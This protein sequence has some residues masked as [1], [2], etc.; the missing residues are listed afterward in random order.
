[1]AQSSTEQ[2][3]QVLNLSTEAAQAL[4]EQAESVEAAIALHFA[5]HPVDQPSSASTPLQRL[6]QLIP[7][8]GRHL[9]HLLL[10][11]HRNNVERAADDYFESDQCGNCQLL[12]SETIQVED[13]SEGSGRGAADGSILSES[14]RGSQ[15]Q[16]SPSTGADPSNAQSESSD[17]SSSHDGSY[18][19]DARHP[20]ID[21]EPYLIP[22]DSYRILPD[23]GDDD[24]DDDA[25][26]ISGSEYTYDSESDHAGTQLIEEREEEFEHSEDF[27]GMKVDSEGMKMRF[28]VIHKEL[29]LNSL[30]SL[31][32][33]HCSAF[34][35]YL[36]IHGMW[37]QRLKGT[38]PLMQYRNATTGRLH[39]E[40]AA[41]LPTHESPLQPLAFPIKIGSFELP[42]RS[43]S[44][45]LKDRSMRR[46][47]TLNLKD[48]NLVFPVRQ[49][50]LWNGTDC[51]ERGGRQDFR[52]KI[53]H[54]KKPA[55]GL[56][57]ELDYTSNLRRLIISMES[58]SMA[59]KVPCFT[60]AIHRTPMQNGYWRFVL[61]VT[62]LLTEELYAC[63][64]TTAS[65]ADYFGHEVREV[66]RNILY[67]GRGLKIG[68][69][70]DGCLNFMDKPSSL[71]SSVS[72]CGQEEGEEQPEVQQR[73][74][75]RVQ[76][77]LIDVALPPGR[78]STMEVCPYLV[79][80][81]KNYQ[82]IG[83]NW[84][85]RRERTGSALEDRGI[86]QLHPMW[87]QLI[88]ADGHIVYAR[89]GNFALSDTFFC[90]PGPGTTG[91]I[92]SDEMGLGKSIQTLML[93]ICNPAPNDWAVQS[94]PTERSVESPDPIPIKTTLIVVPANLL[95]QWAEEIEAHV[96]PGALTWC[97][98]NKDGVTTP[99]M[100]AEE[101]MPEGGGMRR[102][103]R[104]LITS[105]EDINRLPV[106]SVLCKKGDGST[107]LMHE[108]DICLMSYEHL[109]SELGGVQPGSSHLH[110]Y[111]FWRVVLD[112][113]QLVTNSSSVAA[114]TASSLWRRHAW[115]VTGTPITQRVKEVKGLLEFLSCEP[116]YQPEGW[117]LL[118]DDRASRKALPSLLRGL[119][120]RRTKQA[121]QDELAL[122]TCIREDLWVDLSAVERLV[123]E[124]ARRSFVEGARGLSVLGY[125]TKNKNKGQSVVVGRALSGYTAMRQACCHPQLQKRRFNMDKERLSMSQIL[126]KLVSQAYADWD[127]SLRKVLDARLIAA[128]IDGGGTGSH[129]S[130][131]LTPIIQLIKANQAAALIP[132]VH[133][134]V[135]DARTMDGGVH[136]DVA[137]VLSAHLVQESSSPIAAIAIGNGGASGSG[138]KDASQ[139]EQH[140]LTGYMKRHNVA[141]MS[142]EAL[143]AGAAGVKER[144]PLGD[145]SEQD[146]QE[147]K[148]A[149][150]RN[151][152]WR[153]FELSALEL[154]GHMLSECNEVSNET[155]QPV[156]KRA[157][158]AVDACTTS[159]DVPPV[160]LHAEIQAHNCILDNLRCELGLVVEQADNVRRSRR[161][162]GVEVD[163]DVEVDANDVLDQLQNAKVI[164]KTYKDALNKRNPSRSCET[165]VKSASKDVSE[166]WHHLKHLLNKEQAFLRGKA[167]VEVQGPSS[168]VEQLEE[169]NTCPICLDDLNATS[170]SITPCGHHYHP[171]CIRECLE[172]AAQCPICRAPLAEGALMEAISEEE[173]R[174]QE[175][176][177]L[178][179]SNNGDYG[180]KITALLSHFSN[181]RSKDKGSKAVV[182][183]SWGRLLRL[184]NIAFDQ[185]GLGNT[186]LLGTS[187]ELRQQAVHRFLHDPDCVVLTLLMSNA[188]GAA[189]LTL[190]VANYAYILEPSLNP[191]LEA[192]ASARIYRLGQ[193]KETR[194]VR[195]LARST[196]EEIIVETQ[197]KKFSMDKDVSVVQEVE[198]G[199]LLQLYEALK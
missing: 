73:E 77:L 83:F 17:A 139:S 199:D 4:L 57:V 14:E 118:A 96:K 80:C 59:L 48:Y 54:K 122:P 168:G 135:Q 149:H 114:I 69:D 40:D 155:A 28:P 112:E 182:F 72:S 95:V 144:D 55:N 166:K 185:A 127:A 171:E 107:V 119:L 179:E 113:A 92:L 15:Q 6:R 65:E 147:R 18:D 8:L 53:L 23:E 115:V 110:Q 163:E 81:P 130:I 87:I 175:E 138:Q 148:D 100:L 134:A 25:E 90:A 156:H 170:R 11:R 43:M 176:A 21:W 60:F 183:S 39:C 131:R 88:T 20:M 136:I 158:R 186:T 197:R 97:Y 154:Y 152:H 98:Y 34:L 33:L 143:P 140:T 2:I 49:D 167:V 67:C 187:P 192:Q 13:E 196:V 41:L 63:V 31:D 128:A 123:Y 177:K 133:V 169:L 153:R 44:N 126:R 85:L 24:L 71:A 79:T 66:L 173:A 22:G 184:A 35:T 30:M 76:Q 174:L 198:A 1:M 189:G 89:K 29:P 145:F 172:T 36:Q 194:V 64:N 129:P 159:L 86:L 84:M 9:A 19:E 111:G 125:A 51:D 101:A 164:V 120:L 146:T 75:R 162:A 141:E 47:V 178:V 121:V 151:R 46:L 109:R 193:M 161:Q 124:Q 116:Y 32:D 5:T 91:G 180:A 78:P 58:L 142:T 108:T 188:S 26:D 61:E 45:D 70:C 191:G 106:S 50:R 52:F 160:S 37:P 103:R 105:R 132:D 117:A 157:R 195:L 42:I 68:P 82:N 74:G 137:A 99:G 3:A 7:G 104:R 94:L 27:W 56:L 181:M 93:I 165:A 38:L 150:A 102:S 16:R 190:N 10:R 62:F 12:P